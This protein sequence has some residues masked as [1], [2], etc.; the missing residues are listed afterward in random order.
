VSLCFNA[1]NGLP[2]GERH[3][4]RQ[5]FSKYIA[6]RENFRHNRGLRLAKGV[7]ICPI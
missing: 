6:R 4:A 7:G 1:E 5:F 3:L 2:S